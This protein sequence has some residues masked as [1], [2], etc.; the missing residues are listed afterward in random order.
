MSCWSNYSSHLS[1]E[2][3]LIGDYSEKVF[4]IK[5]NKITPKH[6]ALRGNLCKISSRCDAG[7]DLLLLCIGWY[8]QLLTLFKILFQRIPVNSCC[9]ILT[10]KKKK[11][12]IIFDCWLYMGT[13]T[14]WFTL[15]C[16]HFTICLE[17][18][19]FFY[20]FQVVLF[21]RESNKKQSIDS[22]SIISLRAIE[23]DCL[24]LKYYSA[25]FTLCC[26]SMGL[27]LWCNN[28]ITCP[29]NA[30]LLLILQQILQYG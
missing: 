19:N 7:W 12:E 28:S 1:L 20:R 16:N 5:I 15:I 10:L 30:L 24:G 23:S 29:C 14:F 13:E 21:P 6:P 3:N 11:A 2:D 26:L 18:L 8:Y 17:L 9:L 25:L 4:I 22:E 27:S